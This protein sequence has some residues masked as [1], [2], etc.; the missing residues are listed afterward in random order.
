[1]FT[2]ILKPV[3]NI[4]RSRGFLSIVYLDDMLFMGKNFEGCKGNALESKR[5]LLK[6]GFVINN[7]KTCL[8]PSQKCKF[9]GFII[10]SVDY[11]IELTDKKKNPIKNLLSIFSVGKEF[12]MRHFAQ[13]ERG[14]PAGSL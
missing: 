11:T 8:V 10:N 2:K 9:L 1:M 12:S 4:L 14:L 5:L 13:L 3:M 6:L 7:K